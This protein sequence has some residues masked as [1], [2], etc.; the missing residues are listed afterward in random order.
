MQRRIDRFGWLAVMAGAMV[1]SACASLQTLEPVLAPPTQYQLD[2]ATAVE[3]VAADAIGERCGERGV[4]H[5]GACAS[6]ELITLPDPCEVRGDAY[7]QGLCGSARTRSA[8]IAFVHPD[9]AAGQCGA[10][11]RT[12]DVVVC[13]TTDRVVAVNPCLY[14]DRERPDRG[15]PDREWYAALACHEIAHANGWAAHHPGGSLLAQPSFVKARLTA[16]DVLPA[17]AVRVAL[18]AKAGSKAR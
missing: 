8:M 12:E 13:E 7:A 2:I 5:S 16:S 4:R 1:L 6:R 9:L 17:E 10:G 14:P 3:F 15:W 18:L 11:E